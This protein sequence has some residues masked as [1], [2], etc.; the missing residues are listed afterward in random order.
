MMSKILKNKEFFLPL[1]LTVVVIVLDQIT[2]ALVVAKIPPYGL[3][4]QL[5]GDFFRIVHVYNTG[6]AFSLGHDL[7]PLASFL[8]LRI[9]PLLIMIVVVVIYF[10][11][12]SFS[13][14][15]RWFIA[16][17]IGGGFG[18]LIDRFFNSK[19]VVDFIDVKFY[20]IFG[21]QRWPTFNIAD[22]SIVICGILLIIS[23]IIQERKM[24]KEVTNEN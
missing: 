7:N 23:F 12:K 15:Q 9:L 3:G 17:I 10:K 6:A 19:G 5:F 8:F 21:M 2:K 20:G 4:F 24:K 22:S 16:G 13:Y 11:T 18:N 14:P 1:L